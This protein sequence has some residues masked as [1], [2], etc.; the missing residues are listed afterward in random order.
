MIYPIFGTHG[1]D[2]N[3]NVYDRL[4]RPMYKVVAPQM[5][6]FPSYST[7]VDYARM[8]EMEEIEASAS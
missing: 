6:T 1:M 2:E 4:V 8:L 5:K 3:W 7:I